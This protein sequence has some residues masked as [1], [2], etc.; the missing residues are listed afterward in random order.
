[1]LKG[2]K[3]RIEWINGLKG[4]ACIMVFCHHFFLS[5]YDAIYY[6]FEGNVKTASGIDAAFGTEPIGV[7]LNGNFA[8]CLFI[9][10]SAF[11]YAGK[12]MR[13]TLE[14]RKLDFFKLFTKRY[15][16]LMPSVALVGIIYYVL[17]KLLTHFGL[18]PFGFESALS[19]SELIQHILIYQ[20][21]TYDPY[22]LGPLW[23]M[24]VLFLGTF[25][26]SFFSLFSKKN[27]WYMPFVYGVIAVCAYII[28]PYFM[29][30]ILGVMLADFYYFDRLS[31]LHIKISKKV[32]SYII[33]FIFII[34]GLLLG[35]YPSYG[36]PTN[37]L[38]SLLGKLPV[39]FEFLHSAGAFLL[40]AGIMLLPKTVIL[41]SRV[42]GFLGDISF[43]IYLFHSVI[44]NL[45]SYVLTQRFAELTG[46][47]GLSV[48]LC[49]LITL[50]L[51]I[52][53]SVLFHK[54]FEEKYLNRHR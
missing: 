46:N 37:S 12:V 27:V 30:V 19:V 21:I 50:A 49:F 16:R 9:M 45:L 38:Y 10:I 44:I 39:G 2:S 36:V 47:Y 53:V 28:S 54:F 33:G 20:W 15:L 22:I 40:M 35:G 7:L 8:V 6:G 14:D 43:G 17:T 25:V 32:S 13:A 42:F 26:A 41:S 31:E 34:A 3:S 5:F 4:M 18:N 48:F 11:L 52:P 23:C 24:Y 51:L 29:A 1:M